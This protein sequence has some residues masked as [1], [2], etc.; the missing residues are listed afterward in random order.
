MPGLNTA[1]QCG[2]ATERQ[3]RSAFV[4]DIAAGGEER[5]NVEIFD[6]ETESAS[7]QRA[8]SP[9]A[10]ATFSLLP[11]AHTTVSVCRLHHQLLSFM[12]TAR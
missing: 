6:K 11:S 9:A 1:N 12:I 8:I 10:N 5:K 4:H 2:T 3:P 7:Q